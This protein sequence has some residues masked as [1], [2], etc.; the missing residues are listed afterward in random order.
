M[1][2]QAQLPSRLCLEPIDQLWQSSKAHIQGPHATFNLIW[3]AS[4]PIQAFAKTLTL[5]P[6]GDG[7]D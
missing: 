5:Q 1:N 4:E 2:E 6:K 3:M 7:A